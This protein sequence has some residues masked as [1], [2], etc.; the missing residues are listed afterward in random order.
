MK[1]A[2]TR[3]VDIGNMKMN[4]VL[5]RDERDP[6]TAGYS[7]HLPEAASWIACSLMSSLLRLEKSGSPELVSNLCLLAIKETNPG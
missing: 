1:L 5:P 4:L 6:I 3:L 7:L 2:S